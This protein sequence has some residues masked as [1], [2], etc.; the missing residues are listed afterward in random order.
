MHRLIHLNISHFGLGLSSNQLGWPYNIFVI[1][2]PTLSYKRNLH[3]LAYHSV[4]SVSEYKEIYQEGCMS[5]LSD[6][7]VNRSK[8][9]IVVCYDVLRDVVCAIKSRSLFSICFQH[10][11]D[12]IFGSLIS[13]KYES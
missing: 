8:K 13:D 9:V 10:E 7:Y 6:Y 5:L 2:L 4:V 1:Y 3:V 11:H 12:H